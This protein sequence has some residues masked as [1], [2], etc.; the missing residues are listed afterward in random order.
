MIVL[1]AFVV[2]WVLSTV[3]LGSLLL[4]VVVVQR[5]AGLAAKAASVA[6]RSAREIAVVEPQ[7]QNELLRAS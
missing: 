6:R 5:A 4:V 1:H 2:G 3:V 7:S